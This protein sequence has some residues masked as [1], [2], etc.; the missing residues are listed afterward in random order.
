MHP[1]AAI[2]WGVVLLHGKWGT[3]AQ[4]APVAAA[5]QTAGARVE[6]PEMPY[7]GRRLYDRDVDGALAE[8]DAAVAHLR[9][10][11][12]TGIAIGGQSLGANLA[13][14]YAQRHPEVD[15]LVLIAPGGMTDVQSA[16][17]A[18]YVRKAAA[19]VSAGNGAAVERFTD[20][21]TGA[22]RRE[23]EMPAATYLAWFDPA[24]AMAMT[25]TIRALPE[26]L[27]VLLA[28]PRLDDNA[29]RIRDL[30][31]TRA[32]TNP[33]SRYVDVPGDHLDAPRNAAAEAAAWLTA[34][35]R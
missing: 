19:L 35:S 5:M 27:P 18:P 11:G 15:A 32:A 20:F 17:Y 29:P 22:R 31:F 8:I 13:A 33:R 9:A 10:Q 25:A 30:L 1:A 16:A 2:I 23:L 26:T 21:N 14:A 3:P 34:L 12:A 4:M 6:T 24:G 7:S 28:E